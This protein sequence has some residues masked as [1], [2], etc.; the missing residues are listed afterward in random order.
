MQV[1]VCHSK[2]WLRIAYDH[3]AKQMSECLYAGQC[4]VL[5]YDN[6]CGNKVVGDVNERNIR[7]TS[8]TDENTIKLTGD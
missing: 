5:V 6:D 2:H 3:K 7:D 1:G 8:E 4:P